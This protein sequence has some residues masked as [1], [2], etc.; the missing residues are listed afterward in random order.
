MQWTPRTPDRLTQEI[1]EEN[2]EQ[3]PEEDAADLRMAEY[4]KMSAKEKATV[5]RHFQGWQISQF[6]Q[7]EQGALICAA[8]IV[9]QCR[10]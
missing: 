8:K 10:T 2:P 5:R 4:E 7:G 9:T 3:L 6:M 1:D